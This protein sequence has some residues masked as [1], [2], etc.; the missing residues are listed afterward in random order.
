MSLPPAGS[1][2]PSTVASGPALIRRKAGP[3]DLLL[4]PSRGSGL[5]AAQFYLRRGSADEGAG[6]IGLASFTAGMLKRGTRSRS[7]S[8]I[9]F[10]LEALGAFSSHGAG[11]DAAQSSIQCAASDFPAAL[12]VLADC[13]RNPAFDPGELEIE[14]EAVLA[15][16]MRAEDEK[17]EFTYRHYLKRIFQG[18]GYGHSSE[19]EAEDVRAITP[20]SC[21]RWHERAYRPQNLFFVAAGDFDPDEMTDRVASAI[22]GWAESA[23]L[24]SPAR[25]DKTFP[26]GAAPPP[27]V[28]R[29]PLEQGFHIAGFR[30]P[31]LTHPDYP[32]LRLASAALG[33]GFAGRLFTH[34]R[35]ERSLA[36]AV[37]SS[38]YAQRLCGHLMLYIGTQP[39]RL[40][41]ALEGLLAEARALAR[42]PLAEDD[43]E[44][45]RNYVVGK[46][47]MAHQS[48]GARAGFL[49]RWEDL[50]GGA[51]E[52][53]RFVARLHQVDA[54]GILE[55]IRRW[56]TEP[57]IVTLQPETVPA[58]SL[59]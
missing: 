57:V 46:Y 33:E 47:L 3:L 37:G 42:E 19:G 54:A 21:R 26:S 58:P 35:D 24:P 13:L 49:A 22:Q 44:R 4:L 52:D 48:L 32:A 20:E 29:K 41:E 56:W 5:I 30:T 25:Y 1:V 12:E 10:D 38:L 2:P 45:A 6:E 34:L 14:R 31:A 51:E 8:R 43:L 9:A 59:A 16:L 53:G 17:F 39:Q 18:H 23:V 50:G 28:L 55:A 40:D 27:L 11:P 15:H 36:Y 7:S